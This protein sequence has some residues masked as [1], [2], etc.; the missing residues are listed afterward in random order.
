MLTVVAYV[1]DYIDRHSSH[2]SDPLGGAFV[3]SSPRRLT[4]AKMVFLGQPLFDKGWTF[5]SIIIRSIEFSI[6]ILVQPVLGNT[7]MPRHAQP[8]TIYRILECYQEPSTINQV[9]YQLGKQIDWEYLNAYTFALLDADIICPNSVKVLH[10]ERHYSKL[11]TESGFHYRND[12]KTA[13]QRIED[14]I[15]NAFFEDIQPRYRTE[16]KRNLANNPYEIP[17]EKVEYE[18]SV[19]FNNNAPKQNNLIY[20]GLHPKYERGIPSEATFLKTIYP[21]LILPS[22]R[23]IQEPAYRKYEFEQRKARIIHETENRYFSKYILPKP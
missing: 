12:G 9:Y 3:P 23:A 15:T 5:A 22:A 10:K 18:I 2:L 8:Q 7:C 6:S 4:S 19:L 13:A 21:K 20:F 11:K 17:A 14:E 16:I 1:E